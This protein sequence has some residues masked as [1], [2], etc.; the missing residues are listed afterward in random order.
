MSNNLNTLVVLIRRGG[1][2]ASAEAHKLAR[3]HFKVCLTEIAQ[4]LAVS[5]MVAF[6]EAIY[7]SE[8]EI[9]GVVAKL[10]LKSRE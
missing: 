5:R 9:E 2:V 7:D 10:V 8:K 1:E 3:S 4:P 6:S